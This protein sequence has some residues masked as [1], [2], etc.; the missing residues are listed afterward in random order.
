MCIPS[1]TRSFNP[2]ESSTQ[3]ASRSVQPFSH[4]SRR[5]SLYT[6]QW[7]APP[8]SKLPLRIAGS[9]P[10][11]N[12]LF[13]RLIRVNII[14]QHLD[15][16][17]GF[18]RERQIDLQTD[19]ATPSVTIGRICVR[20]TAMRLKKLWCIIARVLGAVQSTIQVCW[21]DSRWLKLVTRYPFTGRVHGRHFGHPCTRPV[22]VTNVSQMLTRAVFTA[23]E[24]TGSVYRP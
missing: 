12:T 6:L 7:A 15:R 22:L 17:S 9:G 21:S 14:K 18:C 23:R 13:P 20:S 19:H 8:P 16:C 4:S 10:L 2:P 1:N 3:T 24:H 5:E 11:F